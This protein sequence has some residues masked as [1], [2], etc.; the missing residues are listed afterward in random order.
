MN[1][2]WGRVGGACG[3]LA[4]VAG[5]FGAHGLRNAVGPEALTVFETAA[6]YHM[7]H[8]LAIVAVALLAHARPSR[9]ARLAG[10]CF[11]AGT[12]LFSGSLYAM[13]LSD[14]AWRFL[15]AVTPLGGMFLI[16]GWV[17]IAVAATNSSGD[18]KG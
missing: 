7:Y 11:L 9:V 2:F 8:A 10:W 13:A 17:F 3:G 16:A 18:Q 12:L 4:V 1:R 14:L 15:G 6:R 5:A